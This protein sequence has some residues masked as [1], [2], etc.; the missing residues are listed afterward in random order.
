MNLLVIT[1]QLSKGVILEL[2]TEIIVDIVIGVFLNT[3]YWRYGLLVS[4]I[5]DR[6]HSLLVPY[7]QGPVSF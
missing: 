5:S 1:D 4:I 2:M 7:R 6:I 3:F